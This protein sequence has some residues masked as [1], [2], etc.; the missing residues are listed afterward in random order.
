MGPDP[1][2]EAGSFRRRGIQGILW[3]VGGHGSAQAIRFLSNLVLARLLFP[4]VFGQA[5]LV[6]SFLTGL[7]LFSDVGTGPAIVQ[8]PR[9][10]EPSF[11]RTAWTV[12]AA[13]GV[14]LW[15]ASF[16]V[17]A[18]AASFYDQ[19]ALR[20][21]IP[22]A[23]FSAAITG[24]ES[25][26]IHLA[27]RRLRLERV[28]LLEIAGQVVGSGVTIALALLER[29]M[30]GPNDPRAIWTIVLGANAAA[31][32]RVI[33]SHT[34]LPGIRHRFEID[35]PSARSLFRFGR[36]I[37]LSTVLT[38]LAGPADRLVFGKLIPLSLLGVYG[39]A[40]N[41]ASLPTDLVLRVGASV[42]FPTFSRLSERGDFDAFFRRVR[43]PVVTG[44]ALLVSGLAAIGPFV[45]PILYDPRYREAGWIVQ[46]LAAM[47]WF[48]IL[49]NTNG[50]ALLATGRSDWMAGG[51]AAK[52]A[53]MLVLIPTGFALGGFGG[54]LAGL[55]AA[56]ALRYLV[57]A[58]GVRRRGLHVLAVDGRFTVGVAT[59]A[60]AGFAAGHATEAWTG[61]RFLALFAASIPPVV[62]WGYLAIRSWPAAR[63]G[64]VPGPG[65]PS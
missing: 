65:Q 3:T 52:L 16:L 43:M 8:N 46:F 37:F 6:F 25:T 23:A 60:A 49:E 32:V 21:L 18:P 10:E 11:L 28:T 58:L 62:V 19:P 27:R 63:P 54:A 61:S 53:G 2:T 36:W 12:A 40:A 20:W 26:S 42:V 13:R 31:L 14:I 50:S 17:A 64:A 39:I 45:I 56:E 1:V 35:R 30:H 24:F 5:A 7:A 48:Q 29:R 59:V 9:G 33:L 44:G 15:I 47:S 41:L 51:N 38:F 57:S 55:V 4:A 22:A 34:F